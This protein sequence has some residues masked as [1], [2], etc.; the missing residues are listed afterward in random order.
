M[1][2]ALIAD[3]VGQDKVLP[4]ETSVGQE[5][6]RGRID[7]PKPELKFVRAEICCVLVNI[8]IQNCDLLSLADVQRIIHSPFGTGPRRN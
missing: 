2:T 5:I 8:E 7:R 4:V 6:A 3:V 1:K